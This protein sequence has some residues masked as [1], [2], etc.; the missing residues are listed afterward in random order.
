MSGITAD[1]FVFPH[2]VIGKLMPEL[3]EHL[4]PMPFE[5]A[6]QM[7]PELAEDLTAAGYTVTGGH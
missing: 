6:V 7:E 4:H 5:S 3:Y 1:R 2:E